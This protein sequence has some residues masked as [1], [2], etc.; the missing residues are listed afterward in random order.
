MPLNGARLEVVIRTNEIDLGNPEI[1]SQ[2]YSL[3][4]VRLAI[5]R[6]GSVSFGATADAGGSGTCRLPS[7][8][9]YS[10]HIVDGGEDGPMRSTVSVVS[11]ADSME[12]DEN[13]G[14]K[15]S[16]SIEPN[17]IPVSGGR[18]FVVLSKLGGSGDVVIENL[19]LSYSEAEDPGSATGITCTLSILILSVITNFLLNK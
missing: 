6:D 12:A 5:G 19:A 17:Q 2:G 4:G 11:C 10:F 18:S 8:E 7:A 9:C 16:L 14:R 15:C 3:D 13:A 1:F